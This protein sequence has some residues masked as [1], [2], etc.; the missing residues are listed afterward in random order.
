[1]DGTLREGHISLSGLQLRAHAM[2]SAE[3]LPLGADTLE[4]AWL[5]DVQAGSVTAM[6]TAPQLASLLD[7]GQ[8]FVFHVVCNEFQLERPKSVV[9][10]QHGIDQRICDSKISS[11][12]GLCLTADDL[13]YRMTRLAV[14]G[15]DL[16]IVEH[17]CATN[18]KMGAIR[19]AN[20]NLHNRAVGEGISAAIQDVQLRQYIEQLDSSKVGLQPAVLR[21]A[22]WLETGSVMFGL[23][24]AD[25]ALAAD[26]SSKHEVQRHFL[27][28]HDTRSKRL[29]FLWPDDTV[30]NKR[31]RNKCGCLGGCR[32]FGGTNA[33]LDFF[34]LEELTP[35]SSSAFS[36]TSADSDMFYG[37]SLLQP[38]EWIVT[39]EAQKSVEGKNN[40]SKRK[41]WE[42][43]SVVI[44]IERKAQH[45]SLQVPLRSHSSSSSEENSSGSAALPLLAG[46][47]DSPSSVND[48]NIGQMEFPP[49][50]KSHESHGTVPIE[51]T[52]SSP[53]SP[54]SQD[55]SVIH[56][57]LRS[58]LK[59]QASVCSTRLGSTKSL[60][61]AFYVEKQPGAVGV[62]FSSDV[63]RSDENVLDS[64]KQRRSFG[65]FPYTPSADSNSFHQ[66]RSMDSS[67]SMAESEAYFSAAEE[68]E[69]I[70]SDE[71]PGTYPGRKRKKKQT[72]KIDYSRGS[73]YHS[74][75]GPLTGSKQGEARLDARTLPI[76]T[77]TSQASF[78]SALAGE[79]ESSEHVYT[80]E[81][82]KTADNDQLT[83]QPI[84]SCYQNYLSQFQ[85]FNWSVKH[86]GNKRT[87]KSS[88]HRP[89]DLDTPTSEE[90]SSCD[91]LCVPNFK[92]VK[93]GLSANALLDRGMQ[94]M[95]STSSTPYTPLD[96]KLMEHTD[97][98]TVTEEWTIDQ[99]VSH[100]RTTA[101]VE[102]KG[103][104][105]V[106]LSPL[107]AEVLDRYI[108]A[109]VHFTSTHH[110]AA[111]VDNLHAKVLTE[112]VQNSKTTFSENLSAKPETKLSKPEN[113]VLVTTNQGQNKPKSTIKQEKVKI[114][115]LQANVTIPKVNLCLLQASVEETSSTATN[116]NVTHVSLIA[117]CF[118]R[119]AT[120]L[121][122]NRGVVEETPNSTDT[123]R[124]S[125]NFEKYAN[126]SKMQPQ[127][128][129]S[130]RSNAGAEK[131]KE[132]AAKLNV[133]RVHGQLRG[134]D[135]SD[136]G[137]CA[138]TTIPFEK[139]KVLFTLEELDDFTFV[140]ETEQPPTAEVT[141]IGPSQ[142]K[143]GWIMFECGIENL[144]VK[145]GRQSGALLYNSFGLMGKSNASG[146]NGLLKSNDSSDSPTGSGYSTD[147]S[148]DNIPCDGVSP[149]SEVNGNSVSDDQ[150]E[151]VESDDLKKDLPL[152]PP[153]PDSSSMKL[154]IKEIWF[155][156][157]APTNVR[158][159]TLTYSRQLNLL[160]TATPAIGSWLVP[161]DQLKSSLNKLETEGT[162]RVCAVMGCIMTEALENKSL[163][164]PL[165]SKYNR[166]TKQARFLQENPSCLLCNLLHHYLHQ[167]N[168]SVIEDATM[169]DGLPALVTLKKGLVAL[170]RQWMKFIVVTPAFKGVRLLRPAQPVKLQS[171][172]RREVQNVNLGNPSGLQSDT[173]ADG[174]EF[175][176]DA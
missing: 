41:E 62:Q 143:W 1:M 135:T 156:F 70:S 125:V 119:I 132:V 80:I 15:A 107:V 115:G 69:P 114:K 40:G 97:D 108:E 68:F 4:Y 94:L 126:A 166:L 149:S 171:S 103:T 64:P 98:E 167:A 172:I 31:S 151:G 89:L 34:K 148:D 36:S 120:Q 59:R 154:T 24:T 37:Q 174:A 14:D 74:V 176:F 128:S 85:V 87:S 49:R 10:C 91:H 165:R 144:T 81:A 160:S 32:F 50:A 136:V 155:S 20:C 138:I 169:S 77:H 134:L 54:N 72:Q 104:V 163:H 27:E 63:S 13:K 52:G 71:G 83:H 25:I 38:A 42:S 8:T 129:G 106:V 113:P 122:M 46:E 159:P 35:S 88:L 168:Y 150:D 84:M 55:R 164:F 173:S 95:G 86:P 109:M 6:A 146:K 137:T 23:I 90:S 61:A 76:R 21:R 161:I 102:V 48:E 82:D 79:E 116:K 145:G 140:D 58:P 93:Q 44:E 127:S 56:S 124:P 142:E 28:T 47:K 118:D 110:P 17:G 7:W 45:L 43:R 51:A 11:Y 75:E 92:V 100:T 121:R 60:S 96:K 57:P 162:L 101:I 67:M 175:D 147:V 22:Y 66:Y 12:P 39:K 65:S 5:I 2:F 123:G 152:M 33:G 29:W 30:K 158:S 111:I 9:I 26:H 73:I 157:A 117:L 78:V 153:P 105:D 131:G 130:L 139:S 170:A 112:A 3:G 16:Y 19:L 141:R 133:H 53:V 18:L 99:P